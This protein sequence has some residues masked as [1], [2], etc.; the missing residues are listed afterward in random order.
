MPEEALTSVTVCDAYH[1]FAG[2]TQ[3]MTSQSRSRTAYLLQ[4]DNTIIVLD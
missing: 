3:L 2:K 4:T 1:Y